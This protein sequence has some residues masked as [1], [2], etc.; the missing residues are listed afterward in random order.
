MKKSW[1]IFILIISIV[2]ISGCTSEEK[3]NSETSVDSQSNQKS[4]TQTPDLIIKPSDVPGLTLTHYHF[5]AVP[6]NISYNYD[7]NKTDSSSQPYKDD[8]PLGTRNVG[9]GS[10][11]RDKFGHDLNYIIYKYDSDSG[12][13]EYHNKL[14]TNFNDFCSVGNYCG[15]RDTIQKNQPDISTAVV[16]FTYNNNLVILYIV[17][18]KDKSLKEAIK[19]AKI[20]ESRLD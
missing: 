1:A 15:Y 4:D 8:L 2:L 7:D 5:K 12:F 11:W 16:V 13:E 19:I 9:E 10:S 14:E 20:I 18:E 6:K 3:T 17:D